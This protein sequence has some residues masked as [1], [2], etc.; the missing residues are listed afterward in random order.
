MICATCGGEVIWKG[1][2]SNLTHTECKSCGRINNQVT[3]CPDDDD[4]ELDGDAAVAA[5][6]GL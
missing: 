6:Y 5:H 2:F 3:D 1:P 4:D